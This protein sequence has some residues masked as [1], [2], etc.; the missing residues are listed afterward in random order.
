MWFLIIGIQFSSGAAMESVKYRTE[1]ACMAAAKTV[2]RQ[3]DNA[4]YYT[5]VLACTYGG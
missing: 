4:H 3:A 5:P 2:K 1:A